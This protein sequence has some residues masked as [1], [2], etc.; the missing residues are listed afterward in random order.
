MTASAALIGNIIRK[1]I[2]GEHYRSEIVAPIDAQ[3]L[4]YAIEFFKRVAE[5]KMRHEQIT[6]DW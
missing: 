4:E 2:F 3:F 5:A 6:V 1:L